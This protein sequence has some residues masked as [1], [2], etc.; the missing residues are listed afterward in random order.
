MLPCVLLCIN[1]KCRPLLIDEMGP[2]K[3][4]QNPSDGTTM[5]SFN[6]LTKLQ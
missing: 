1:S 2:D 3:V 5:N 4:I 6:Y